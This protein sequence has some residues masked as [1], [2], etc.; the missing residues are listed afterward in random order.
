LRVPQDLSVT[1]FDDTYVATRLY[2]PL[3]TIRQPIREMGIAAVG[4][5]LGLIEGAAPGVIRLGH[6]LVERQ[7]ATAPGRVGK[8]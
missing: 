8:P 6:R 7:S 4:Q 5:L 3:T 1:G 2:P